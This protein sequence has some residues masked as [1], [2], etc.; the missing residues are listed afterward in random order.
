MI[1]KYSYQILWDIGKEQW[2]KFIA[3]RTYVRATAQN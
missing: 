1:A 2:H 3:W